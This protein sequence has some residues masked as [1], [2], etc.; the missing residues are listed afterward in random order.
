MSLKNKMNI[1]LIG[2]SFKTG[3]LGVSALA[4]SSIKCI[5]RC[6]PNANITI[7]TAG[8]RPS[9]HQLEISG[10][11]LTVRVL[12]IRF[13]PKIFVANH[14]IEIV[15]WRLLLSIANSSLRQKI[16]NKKNSCAAV[17]YNADYVM[18]ITGGDSFSD[19]YG[20]QR[21]T[22]GMLRKWLVKFYGKPLILLPQTYGP[23]KRKSARYAASRV[24][25][26]ASLVFSRDKEG[27]DT[28]IELLADKKSEDKIKCVADLAFTLDA[29]EPE[30]VDLCG[31]ED[32]PEEKTVLVGL[33]VSGLL[34]NGGYSGANMFDLKVNYR[35][36]VE[37]IIELV[38]GHQNMKLLLVPHV[39]P[40]KGWEVESDPQACADIYELLKERYPGRIFMARGEY[41]Q[42]EI[43]SIIGKCNF[44][45]GSRM[46]SCI[47]AISQGIPTVGLAY[48]K[49]FTG[50]FET[51]GIDKYVV[52][53]RNCDE[54]DVLSSIDLALRERED[55]ASKL[56]DIIPGIKSEVL[57]IFREHLD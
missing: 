24:L 17:L 30:T 41:D 36:L 1:C 2:A 42:G 37:N 52:D 43:K 8:C 32:L 49:K 16:L 46:H 44:F 27:V 23:F 22:V 3:N 20:M 25:R 55:I 6:W 45:M 50:V 48:S 26:Y 51:V 28:A 14:F 7:F 13:S 18:E 38:L 5:L 9:E 39:F 35:Q 57:N 10:K 47:A 31:L 56:N 40:N 54:S 21:F 4:E 33:N 11:K 12:S 15:I 29:R 34:Y 53:L 19:I